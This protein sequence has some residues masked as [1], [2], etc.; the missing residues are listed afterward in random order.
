MNRRALTYLCGLPLAIAGL[1]TPSFAQQQ[2]AE[3]TVEKTLDRLS[4]TTP[5]ASQLLAPGKK[6]ADSLLAA[7]KDIARSILAPVN[8]FK[9]GSAPFKI[10]SIQ[11]DIDYTYLA[12]TSGLATGVL[13]DIRSTTSYNLSINLSIANM[14]FDARLAGNNGFYDIYNTPFTQFPQFNFN[15]KKYLESLRKQVLGNIN[16]ERVQSS[17][18]SRINTV[19]SQF[20]ASLKNEILQI[21]QEFESEFKT[22]LKLPANITDLSVS[23]MTS[24]R[25]LIL[26]QEV[27]DEYNKGNELF[28]A[29]SSGDYKL[30]QK[31]SLQQ[32]AL[33]QVKKYKRLGDIYEKIA[34]WK[35]N[36]DSNPVV[37]ELRS[38]LPFTSG[39]FA[40][41]I[42][43]PG[44]LVS[45]IK[46]HASLSGIQKLFLNI[47]K[48]DIGVNP[49]SEGGFNMHQVMNNGLNAA[50]TGNRSSAGIIYGTGNANT[51]RWMQSG[52]NSFVSN[53]YSKLV[54]VKL[55]SGWSNSFTQSLSLNFFD[56]SASR[57]LATLDPALLQTGYLAAPARRDAV[58]TWQSSFNMAAGHKISID[59]S[60][61]FGAYNNNFSADSSISK[62]NAFGNIFGNE[63]RSNFAAAIDYQGDIAKTD[64]RLSLRKAGLGY[65]NPG[66][67]FIR[68][69]ET[70][71]GLSLGRKFFKQKLTAKYKTDYRHQHFDPSKNYTYHTFANH[72]QLAYRLKRNTRFGVVVRHHHYQFSNQAPGLSASGKNFSLQGDA[73][74]Q[75]RIKRKKVTSHFSLT[76]QS[77]DI[78]MLTG[79]QYT[80]RAWLMSHTSSLLLNKN[81]VILSMLVNR[82]NNKDYYFNTSFLNTELSYAFAIGK[83][84]ASSG[85]GFYSN[86]GWNKQVGLKQQLS[87]TLFKKMDIA[88]DLTWKKAI[89]TIRKELANQVYISSSVH[90]RF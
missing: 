71:F 27:L 76:G 33:Q 15:H 41:Y 54:G 31:D 53:E 82:S 63:G 9:P 83:I 29:I 85:A 49:L 37:K 90:Y 17:I 80:S 67:M 84:Q 60:K 68:R 36:F 81:L 20:E 61:S 3:A 52:L 42:K 50:V 13:R 72:L 89:E 51:N 77:F 65:N 73:N 69:G 39:N 24:L 23:D 28:Q 32:V 79:Q 14:P 64:V 55:G 26:P 35:K 48:L 46:E 21:L 56:F 34:N 66:N 47:T 74:Y 75:F 8:L 87:G 44:K 2:P 22:T 18:L 25:N 12:D 6:L 57:D 40:T 16:P 19:K 38:N 45:V 10:N 5:S 78:P 7:G 1:A 43:N 30:A 88:I 62:N 70:A 58:V 86:T 11:A 4:S 59:L